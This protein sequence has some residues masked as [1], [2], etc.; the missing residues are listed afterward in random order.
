M[1]KLGAFLIGGDGTAI[2]KLKIVKAAGFDQVCFGIETMELSD[3]TGLTSDVCANVGIEI[4]HLHLTGSGTNYLWAEG[5]KGDTIAD[6]YCKQIEECHQWGVKRGV[7]HALWGTSP[8]P[9]PPS[10]VGLDRFK[11]IVECAEKNDVILGLENSV[12]DHY[13]CYL[14]DNIKSDKLGFCFDSGHHYAFGLDADL[15]DSYADKLAATH[16]HDNDCKHDIHMMPLDGCID[17]QAAAKSMAKAP[18]ALES[19]CA[20]TCGETY[21]NFR[22]KTAAEIEAIFA[23]S[24]AYKDGLMQFSDGMVRVYEGMTYAEKFERLYKKM[25]RFADMIEAEAK[26]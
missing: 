17:W 23:N 22:D 8:A 21:C 19:I 3:K 16:L 20:E 18:Y 25:R 7:L 12:Y 11:R 13:L 9:E 10:N 6:R 2:E 15:F 4:Q 26:A 5:E 24:E 1:I 14:F